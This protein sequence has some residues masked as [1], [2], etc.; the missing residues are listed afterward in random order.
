LPTT[1]YNVDW[2]RAQQRLRDL[3]QVALLKDVGLAPFKGNKFVHETYTAAV[4]AATG[5]QAGQQA[6]KQADRKAP[7]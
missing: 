1:N 6:G 7:C 2:L 5:R 3:P 4:A